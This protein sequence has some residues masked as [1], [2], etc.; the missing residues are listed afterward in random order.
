MTEVVLSILGLYLSSCVF[1]FLLLRKEGD[2]YI[3]VLFSLFWPIIFFYSF[4]KL[5]NHETKKKVLSNENKHIVKKCNH[6]NREFVTTINSESNFCSLYCH[7]LYYNQ[8]K[9]K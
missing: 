3:L 8:P 9:N 5:S 2:P 4:K 6:C 7:D 1:V